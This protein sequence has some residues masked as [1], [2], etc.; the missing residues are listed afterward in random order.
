M[1]GA[2]YIVLD[3]NKKISPEALFCVLALAVISILI[4]T[5]YCF[6]D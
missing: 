4:W 1:I 6:K 5:I 3:P 2:F